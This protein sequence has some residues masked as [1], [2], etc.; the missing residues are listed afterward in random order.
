M[1]DSL[2]DSAIT[3]VVGGNRGTLRRDNAKPSGGSTR[4]RRAQ[5]AVVT[6]T[7]FRHRALPRDSD[8]VLFDER[9]ALWNKR[10]SSG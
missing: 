10:P 5:Q 3:F 4:A 9:Q 1:G 2:N 7:S 6:D 8:A